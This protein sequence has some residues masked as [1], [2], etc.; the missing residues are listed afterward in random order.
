VST[1]VATGLA[2]QGLSIYET[3]RGAVAGSINGGVSSEVKHEAQ[4]G[5]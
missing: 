5:A 4:S 1:R 3:L 2:A